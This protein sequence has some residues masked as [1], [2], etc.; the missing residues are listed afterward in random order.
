[1]AGETTETTDDANK[2][3]GAEFIEALDRLAGQKLYC[4]DERKS[5][6]NMTQEE[7]AVYMRRH[8]YEFVKAARKCDPEQF[9]TFIVCRYVEAGKLTTTNVANLSLLNTSLMSMINS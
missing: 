3:Y 6:R 2:T 7:L 5:F 9:A 4:Y 1:M 8:G